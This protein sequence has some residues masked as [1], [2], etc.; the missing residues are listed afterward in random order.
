MV[1]E[2]FMKILMVVIPA[3]LGRMWLIMEKMKNHSKS[4]SE[5]MVYLLKNEIINTYYERLQKGY[6]NAYIKDR[7]TELFEI[8]KKLGGNGN[9][10]RIYNELMK[11]EEQKHEK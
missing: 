1:E 8:Y 10:E 4:V 2:I 5:G 11:M 7:V 9:V 6:C 3:L